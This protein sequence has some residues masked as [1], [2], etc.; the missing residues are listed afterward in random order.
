M[1]V[2]DSGTLRFSIDARHVRQL[3]RELVADRITA[4]SELIKNAYD[5][6]A[7]RVDV[8][9]TVES[10]LGTGGELLVVDDGQGMSLADVQSRWMV[11]STGFK[12]KHPTSELFQRKRAGQKGI[13]RFATESLGRSLTLSSTRKGSGERVVVDFD[14]HADYTSG[15]NLEQVE[16]HYRIEAAPE[17]EHGT[18]LRIG[19]LHDR[20]DAKSLG[21]VRDAVL[22]L[23]PP[24]RKLG[25]QRTAP[26]GVDPG[27]D[28]SVR[29]E[30]EENPQDTDDTFSPV[31]EAATAWI[32]GTVSE[33]GTVLRSVRSAHLGIDETEQQ[34][35]RAELTGA[36]S[37]RVAYLIFKADALNPDS[38]VGVRKAQQIAKLFGG[39][40]LY[41]DGLRTLPYGE[42]DN[43]W[44]LLDAIYRRRGQVLAP[45]GNSNFFGEILLTR[46]ENV[47][48]V[49]TASREGVVENEAFEELCAVVQDALVWGVN[50]V[51]AARKKKISAGASKPAPPPTR[52][53]LLEPLLTAAD[54]VS[55]ADGDDERLAAITK[56]KE[57]A[58]TTRDRA[59]ADDSNQ[60]AVV[61][62]LLD[63]LSLLRVLASVGSAVSIFSH[64]VRA[65]LTQAL[66]A[67]G[68][69]AEIL[70]GI[71]GD[72][73]GEVVA[74]ERGL[75]D[76]GDL[77]SYLDLYVSQS[78]RRTR[79]E[80]PMSEILET[81]V[82]RIGPLLG[83]RGV[84]ITQTVDPEH[85][86]TAPMS[87]S[88]LEAILYNLLTNAL[89]AMD[90]ENRVHR[91]IH[92]S[93]SKVRDRL[94]IR[95][96]DT[97]HGISDR[98]KDRIFNAFV[99]TTEESDSEL[100]AGSG[101]GLKIV[102]DVAELYGGAASIGEPDTGFT[103][104]LQIDLPRA[105]T[106]EQS[107]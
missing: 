86:R 29:F 45:I 17:D 15:E 33:D 23:Q 60:D 12:D 2:E 35:Q 14:W 80:Q 81:F 70:E 69:V 28:V 47:L 38:T 75:V 57:I 61:V 107:S 48:F 63:E 21:R 67:M 42:P 84:E 95:F 50:E 71:D 97:G 25:D 87:R 90:D 82:E 56:L 85:L 96:Q 5:A 13:G 62:A 18:T 37:F 104:C 83:R 7:E 64:E 79:E 78:G 58:S 73:A 54:D 39:I 46:S 1:T 34:D 8:I 4:V 99:T 101:L 74:A 30:F 6:D 59:Q 65:V 11:I 26:L 52:T 103:T 3:G 49:D 102:A 9:F 43:D 19:P 10:A 68:D 92:L 44:L 77:A 94:R 100:G 27:F 22:L 105:S 16:N 24:F 106:E 76:I 66:G 32:E 41:R 36:F 31:L 91:A 55:S 98:V 72:F 88:E 40:R 53:E 93:A 20:W 89:R 51:A